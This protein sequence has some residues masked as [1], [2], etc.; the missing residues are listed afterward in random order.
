MSSWP[1]GLGRRRRIRR[2]GFRTRKAA[3]EA[4]AQLCRPSGPGGLLT[5]GDWLGQWVATCSG[6]VST[7][8]DNACHIRRYLAPYLGRVVLAELSVVHLQMMSAAIARRHSAGG[9]PRSEPKSA[10]AWTQVPG[11]G[12]TE[13]SACPGQGWCTRRGSNPRPSARRRCSR[14]GPVLLVL[15]GTAVSAPRW[16]RAG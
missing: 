10:S 13:G 15:N 8:S 7:V 5:V 9:A 16:G 12:S 6:A 1:A 3:E 11:R 2:G 4:L 14:V